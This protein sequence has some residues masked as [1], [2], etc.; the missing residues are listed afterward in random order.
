MNRDDEDALEAA[1][2][3]QQREE[4]QQQTIDLLAASTRRPLT[5]DEAMLVAWCAGVSTEVYKEI[6]T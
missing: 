4:W 6:R 1:Q 2:D 3:Q 5:E